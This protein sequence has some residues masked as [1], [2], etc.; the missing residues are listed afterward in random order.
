M[1]TASK[2]CRNIYANVYK[3]KKT[4]PKSKEK[5]NKLIKK[6]N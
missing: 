5:D 4:T 3:K 6:E 2:M 1:V